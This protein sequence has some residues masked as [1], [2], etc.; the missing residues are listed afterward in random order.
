M[1]INECLNLSNSNLR[2]FFH[3][4]CHKPHIVIEQFDQRKTYIVLSMI[5]LKPLIQCRQIIIVIQ[6]IDTLISA[7]SPEN[8]Q[9]FWLILVLTK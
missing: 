9:I 8:L 2:V 7:D 4:K 6:A 5:L 3:D 1:D